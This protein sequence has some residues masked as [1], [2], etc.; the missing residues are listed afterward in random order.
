MAIWESLLGPPGVGARRGVTLGLFRSAPAVI[1]IAVAALAL[2]SVTVLNGR[3]AAFPDTAYYYS[4]GLR[5]AEASGWADP[6]DQAAARG[7]PTTLDG[8]PSDARALAITTARSRAPLYGALLYGAHRLGSLWGLA[9]LQCAVAAWLIWLTVNA[10]LGRRS[11]G[12]YQAIIAALAVGSSLPLF[13]SMAM[14]DIFAGL[15]ALGAILLLVCGRRLSGPEQAG[16]FVLTVFAAAAHPTHLGVLLGLVALAAIACVWRPVRV[17]IGRQVPMAIGLAA[18]AAA[19]AIAAASLLGSLLEPGPLRLPVLAA[20]VL[21]DGPGRLYLASAC[22]QDPAAFALCRFRGLPLDDGEAI[23]WSTDP[24]TGVFQLANETTRRRIDA[25]QARFVLGAVRRQPLLELGAM[26]RNWAAQLGLYYVE[27]PLRNP[28]NFLGHPLLARSA[29]PRLIPDMAPCRRSAQTCRARL[30]FGPL[31]AWH[32]AVLIL[33]LGFV[34]WRLAKAD[35]RR[36]E[37][38]PGWDADDLMRLKTALSLIATAV[39]LNAALCGVLAGPF[40]RYEARLIWLVPLG[41]LLLAALVGPAPARRG[42][43][44][45]SA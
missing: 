15:S 30:P 26:L 9:A 10:V 35:V 11:A 33:A 40:P 41:A 34:A 4:A 2:L 42:Q 43:K 8:P 17:L 3:P 23:I 6:K 21:A 7:D 31:R 14:P 22:R 24:R 29:I 39:L 18:C 37:A 45:M 27:E 25:E 36:G 38:G 12:A 44:S 13:A 5:L 32:G 1:H 20:R 16:L 19:V 28:A